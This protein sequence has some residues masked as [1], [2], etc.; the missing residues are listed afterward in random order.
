MT[1]KEKAKRVR[2]WIDETTYYDHEEENKNVGRIGDSTTEANV[3]VGQS[4]LEIILAY[5]KDK[6][7]IT[8][9][10]FIEKIETEEE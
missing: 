9:K 3:I 8:S 10:N 1:R 6:A 5:I 2:V 4:D 7:K